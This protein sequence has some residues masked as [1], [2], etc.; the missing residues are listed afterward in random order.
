MPFRAGVLFYTLSTP[1]VAEQPSDRLLEPSDPAS[2]P[3]EELFQD[4]VETPPV[5]PG[6]QKRQASPS[7]VPLGALLSSSRISSMSTPKLKINSFIS[8][9]S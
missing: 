3:A 9:V 1:V 7:Q 8:K 5:A 2:P 4:H 6:S